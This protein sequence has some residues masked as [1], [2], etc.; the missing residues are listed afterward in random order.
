M[1]RE[2]WWNDIDY[3]KH[4][5]MKIRVGQQLH[6]VKFPGEHQG[7]VEVHSQHR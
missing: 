6:L 1:S 3:E 2:R 4:E 5:F 7:F